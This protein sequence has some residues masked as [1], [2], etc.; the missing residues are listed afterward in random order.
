VDAT[1]AR[2]TI[3]RSFPKSTDL[4]IVLIG[5]A[6]KI[7]DVARHYGPLTEMKLSDPTFSPVAAR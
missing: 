3:D 6:A 1:V 7:R 2:A 4:A 5:D